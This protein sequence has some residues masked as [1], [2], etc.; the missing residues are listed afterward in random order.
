[1]SRP[2]P[3]VELN[4]AVL[5]WARESSGWKIEDI[6]GKLKVPSKEYERWE[7]SG[8]DIKI[9]HLEALVK[10]YRRSLA[11]F[12]LPNPPHEPKPPKDFRVLPGRRDK[13][14]RRTLFAIRR[15]ERLQS[16]AVDI[17]GSLGEARTPKIG[18]ANYE[19]DPEAVSIRE[20]GHFDITVQDQV[21]WRDES[22]A[23]TT[24]RDAIERRNILVFSLRMPLNDAR[25]FSLSQNQPWAIV[26]N[27]SDASRARIFTLFH[28]YGH[29]LLHRPGV[30]VPQ[31]NWE[32]PSELGKTELWCN[33]FSA[34]FLLPKGALQQFVNQRST[35]TENLPDV[36][37]E[38]SRRFKV[39]QEV[40]VRRLMT[41]KLITDRQFLEQLE[42]LE[43]LPK[44]KRKGGFVSPAVA[45]VGGRGKLFTRLVLEGRERGILSYRD[46]ADFLSIRL[47]HLDKVSSLVVS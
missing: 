7:S 34:A 35:L 4:P 21:S 13:F 14:E 25:G 40:V 38:I 10:Y 12:F 16:K 42:R 15:A 39:S 19:E 5:K 24:W 1:V 36:T 22:I 11:T 33:K 2:S 26:V 8:R 9:N 29:L 37:A 23:L 17:L 20:R 43:S 27:S 47:K 45:S 28:E 6:A 46:V 30:C 31:R 32:K 41:L 44:I 18:K 3:K